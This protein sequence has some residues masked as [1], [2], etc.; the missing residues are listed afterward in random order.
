MSSTTTSTENGV[1]VGK[2]C[3]FYEKNQIVDSG[4]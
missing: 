4:G 2:V 3:K 1:H